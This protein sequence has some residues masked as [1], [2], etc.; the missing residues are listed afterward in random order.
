VPWREPWAGAPRLTGVVVLVTG[1]S[2]GVGKGIAVALGS[3]GATVYVTG[4]TTEGAPAPEVYGHV[5]PG[6]ITAT[7][8]AVTAAGGVGIAVGCDHADDAQSL[9]VVERVL[10][11]QGRIDVLVN[12]ALVVPPQLVDGDP[13][14]VK[15][16][17][18]F[19]DLFHVGVRSTYVMSA[20]V[21]PSMVR[22][23]R[24]LIVTTSGPGAKAY[25]NTPAYGVGKVAVDRMMHDMAIE[26]NPHGVAAMSLWLGLVRTER[27]AVT[28]ERSPQFDL[29][30]TESAMF[31]GRAVAALAGDADV[32]ARTGGTHYVAELAAVYGFDDVDGR[33]PASRR[34]SF[35]EPTAFLPGPIAP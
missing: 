29:T 17:S 23:G 31:A 10:A 3:C 19:D 12:N 15:P 18:V 1:A 8:R 11:E 34:P 26:L 35:G 28:V 2:R 6:S 5:L 4:R 16:I 24:G 32:M 33:R 13:F 30:S 14:W 25:F 22:A 21:A 27:L 7:A 9:A 20:A